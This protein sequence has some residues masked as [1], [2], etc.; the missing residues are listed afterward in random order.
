M[1]Q[2]PVANLLCEPDDVVVKRPELLFVAVVG[3]AWLVMLWW[4]LAVRPEMQDVFVLLNVYV[5]G[6]LYALNLY[7]QQD[8]GATVVLYLAILLPPIA[9]LMLGMAFV[10][11]RF[12]PRTAG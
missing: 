9:W 10:V 7:I 2:V 5:L 11:R 6:I 3:V 1:P 8:Q 4:V 12:G